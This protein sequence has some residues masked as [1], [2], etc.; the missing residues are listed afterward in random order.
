MCFLFGEY[1]QP[2]LSSPLGLVESSWGGTPI[3]AWSNPQAIKDCTT[4]LAKRYESS[5]THSPNALPIRLD[6]VVSLVGGVRFVSR[7]HFGRS[8]AVV[9]G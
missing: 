7:V 3:E 2:L 1:L 4:S 8:D 6:C 5:Q 9:Q